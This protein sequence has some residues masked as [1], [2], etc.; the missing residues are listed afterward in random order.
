MSDEFARWKSLGGQKGP[1]EH[2][3]FNHIFKKASDP[4]TQQELCSKTTNTAFANMPFLSMR[5]A[6]ENYEI[7]EECRKHLKR[8]KPKQETKQSI[9]LRNKMNTLSLEIKDKN[10]EIHRVKY[11]IKKLDKRILHLY[12]KVS[13]LQAKIN[14]IDRYL[15]YDFLYEIFWIPFKYTTILIATIGK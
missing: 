5:S 7:E 6:Y 8:D 2:I 10:S 9:E 4:F 1:D 14:Y 15:N 12:D 3:N 11:G 13:R